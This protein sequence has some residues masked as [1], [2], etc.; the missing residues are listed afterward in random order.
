MGIAG[1]HQVGQ[2]HQGGAVSA[3]RCLGGEPG[4]HAIRPRDDR[5]D[6]GCVLHAVPGVGMRENLARLGHVA[7]H[8]PDQRVR[9]ER[10]PAAA[11][12]LVEDAGNRRSAEQLEYLDHVVRI[13]VERIEDVRHS[14]VDPARLLRLGWQL[15]A[16]VAD[17]TIDVVQHLLPVTA[18]QLDRGGANFHQQDDVR[19]PCLLGTHHRRAARD[20]IASVARLDRDGHQELLEGNVVLEADSRGTD[21]SPTESRRSSR[22][23]NRRTRTRE[24]ARRARSCPPG[25]VRIARRGSPRGRTCRV[26]KARGLA[27]GTA[28]HRG[29]P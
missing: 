27:T 7:A 23:R 8:E 28:L 10:E 26:C 13:V 29:P 5:L 22:A 14:D 9:F 2:E 25:C 12:V 11:H 19:N 15:R 17:V 18:A 1:P 6:C 4:P 20:R 3:L 21:P 16:V 24:P